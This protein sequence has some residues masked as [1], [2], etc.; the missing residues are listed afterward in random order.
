MFKMKGQID[1]PFRMIAGWLRL[2]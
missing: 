2:G 1:Y